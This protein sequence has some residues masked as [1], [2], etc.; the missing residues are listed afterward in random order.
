MY[1][2]RGQ[3]Q[4]APGLSRRASGKAEQILLGHNLSEGVNL[5]FKLRIR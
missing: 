2:V 3:L 4:V 1:R 5:R